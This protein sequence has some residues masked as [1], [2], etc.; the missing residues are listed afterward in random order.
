MTWCPECGLGIPVDEDGCCN[1]CG[2]TATGAGAD[3]AVAAQARIA[4]L[5]AERSRDR[6]LLEESEAYAAER[7]RDAKAWERM[8]L[9]I[10]REC[11]F[12]T[13]G[14]NVEGSKHWTD[15]GYEYDEL[16]AACGQ[17]SPDELDPES[18]PVAFAKPAN[19]AAFARK[20][21]DREMDGQVLHY[22]LSDR[23]AE[24][25]SQLAAAR[26]MA[27]EQWWRALIANGKLQWTAGYLQERLE[28]AA[29]DLAAER[30]AH[31]ETRARLAEAER[32]RD[33]L[34]RWQ[35]KDTFL[36]SK[37][38]SRIAGLG[39]EIA[40]A[41]QTLATALGAD[42]G[43]GLGDLAGEAAGRVAPGRVY[44]PARSM[45]GESNG[46]AME[47]LGEIARA[48]HAQKRG[49]VEIRSRENSDDHFAILW[50]RNR[51]RAVVLSL[52]DDFNFTVT[53]RIELAGRDEEDTTAPASDGPGEE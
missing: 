10:C 39:A 47:W 23:I 26:R 18:I 24:M 28:H 15:C 35:E 14:D 19:L 21:Q 44:P 4:E 52:R 53:L 48:A 46:P 6:K 36:A 13:P 32:S 42:P 29:D 17:A 9:V 11:G 51:P 27:G 3:A 22:E 41:R 20:W 30:A 2:A 16:C 31:A 34:A 37:E 5:E 25:K 12:V 1:L 8:G 38:A 33:V 7:D 43:R 49:M 45:D 50:V 40:A